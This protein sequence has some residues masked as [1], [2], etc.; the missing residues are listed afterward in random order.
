MTQARPAARRRTRAASITAAIVALACGGALC[1]TQARAATEPPT[2]CSW[3]LQSNPDVVNVEYP[4]LSAHYW[5]RPLF[6]QLGGRLVIRGEYPAARYFSFH[7]YD[8]KLVPLDS[9]HDSTVA[10]DRGSSNPFVHRSKRGA[11]NH[12]TVYVEFKP[13][14]SDPAPNT[15]YVGDT[16]QQTPTPEG[17]LM[18]RVYVPDDPSDPAGGVPLPQVTWETEEGA[19]VQE[20]A[21]CASNSIEIGGQLNEEIAN[22]NWPEGVP[23]PQVPEATDPPTWARAFG[24]E[25]VGVW[26]NQQVAYLK[27]TISRQ[28]G[29]VVVIHGKAPTFPNTRAGQPAYRKRQVR[30]WSFCENSETT[31][32]LACKAD[33]QA[34]IDGGYYTYVV[35]D[36]DKRPANATATNG[37]AW[38][39]WGGTMASGQV[40]Y[41]N[42]L[43]ESSFSQAVQNVPE[44]A[45]PQALMGAYFPQ[46]TYC[47][48]ATFEA[49]GLK[50]CESQ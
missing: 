23:A 39:P 6:P 29:D 19:T 27:A 8:E 5:G 41:R 11:S 45:S 3:G 10:P 48:R 20:Y 14:P 33:Y 34:P 43:P 17:T 21:P 32:V 9:V 28:Y 31:R 26:A 7:V 13:K 46:I 40:I 30:Y 24:S 18:Y 37:V 35:S 1:G 36:P 44:G 16:P 2:Q 47:T 4:D 49:G 12:Y 22:S 15:L 25:L 42:M 38:L 50:A